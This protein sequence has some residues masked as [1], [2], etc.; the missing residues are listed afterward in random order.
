MALS[1]VQFAAIAGGRAADLIKADDVRRS[2]EYNT[3]FNNFIDNNVGAIKKAS[4]KRLLL[5]NKMKK[6]YLK[7]LI[8]MLKVIKYN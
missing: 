8:L 4:A 3:A 2:K 7:L 6:I 1:L 5:E